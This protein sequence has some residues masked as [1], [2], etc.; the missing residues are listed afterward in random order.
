[1]PTRVDGASIRAAVEGELR[2][3][4]T[5]YIDLLQLHWPDRYTCSF[6]NNQYQVRRKLDLCTS[7]ELDSSSAGLE[8][9]MRL[10]A[11]RHTSRLQP[12]HTTPPP[13]FAAPC[14]SMG[15]PQHAM[16]VV[17]PARHS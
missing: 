8:S 9:D 17:M 12:P 10:H 11:F 15:A 4:Q 13:T 1:M 3:L 14:Q 5:D 7:T 2:R 16:L 6:G